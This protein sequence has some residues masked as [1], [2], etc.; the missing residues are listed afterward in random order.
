MTPTPIVGTLL[1]ERDE[2]VQRE[3][4]LREENDYLRA[5]IA[6]SD[7]PCLY[8]KLPKERMAECRS[9][10]PG[11]GRMDDIQHFPEGLRHG[12]QQG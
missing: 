2:A 1:K 8:C 6:N 9:G 12:R 7:L 4:R 11:C 5:Y 3:A 10:F